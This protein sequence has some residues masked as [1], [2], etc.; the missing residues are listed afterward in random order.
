MARLGGFVVGN[1]ICDH[2]LFSLPS[3]RTNTSI[4][5]ERALDLWGTAKAVPSC[6]CCRTRGNALKIFLSG[7]HDGGRR[8]G[9]KRDKLLCK[10]RPKEAQGGCSGQTTS[11]FTIVS[12]LARI[13]CALRFCI[14]FMSSLV[15]LNPPRPSVTL[16]LRTLGSAPGIFTVAE[17]GTVRNNARG[18]IIII[19]GVLASK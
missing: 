12:N 7:Q 15:Q 4:S 13:Y 9:S 16:C 17:D 19:A 5:I 3:S 10:V 6:N 14:Y 2:S 1:I 8:D 18:R 11:P